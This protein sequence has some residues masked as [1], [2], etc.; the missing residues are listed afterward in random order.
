MV[1]RPGTAAWIS[2][3]GM[4]DIPDQPDGSPSTQW[5]EGAFDQFYERTIM[6]IEGDRIFLDA[7]LMNAFDREFGD[8][9][10]GFS[11]GYVYHYDITER[12]ENVG[13]EHIR[14]LSKFDSSEVEDGQFIDEDHAW[15]FVVVGAAQDVWVRNVT[16]QH[17]AKSTVHAAASSIRVTV[18][19]ARSEDPVS[20][21]RGMRR[22]PFLIDGQFVLM[23]NLHSENGRHDFATTD[24]R[25][26]RGPNVFLNAR[27]VDSLE[28]IGPHQKWATGDALRHCPDRRPHRGP[29]PRQQGQRSRLGRGEPRVLEQYC[30]R[31]RRAEPAHRPELGDR[32]AGDD[33]RG[34]QVRRAGE[35]H[36]PG[37]RLPDRFRRL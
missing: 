2:H 29:Q 24:K 19:N 26:N 13:V 23:Q 32:L 36:L 15:K 4:D 1:E 27:A 25:Q 31:V 20:E 10:A 30:G 28:G 16:G 9:D 17:F 3:I 22:Y 18:Y 21:V 14:G 11:G 33:H 6:R 7:P 35:R 37:T 5:S 12:I 8:P 34:G